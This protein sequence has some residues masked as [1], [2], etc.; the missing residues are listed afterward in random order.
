MELLTIRFGRTPQRFAPWLVSMQHT[1]LLV[2]TVQYWWNCLLGLESM[3]SR[4]SLPS[5]LSLFQSAMSGEIRQR[6]RLPASART[7][8]KQGTSLQKTSVVTEQDA[9]P[10]CQLSDASGV[11]PSFPLSSA[12]KLRIERLV[13]SLNAPTGLTDSSPSCGLQSGTSSSTGNSGG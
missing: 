10:L 1:P 6:N 7:T 12:G 13:Q 5:R 11:H 8:A 9:P 3:E 2:A 4:C